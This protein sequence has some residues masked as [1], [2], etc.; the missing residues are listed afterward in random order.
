MNMW[1]QLNQEYFS[2]ASSDSDQFH[3]RW[4]KISISGTGKATWIPLIFNHLNCN[5]SYLIF[6][7]FIKILDSEN[8]WKSEIEEQKAVIEKLKEDA[9][10]DSDSSS[11]P[12][13]YKKI[14]KAK[15]I[16]NLH[17]IE[18]EN[19][20]LKDELKDAE[21]KLQAQE[22]KLDEVKA[23]DE[24]LPDE[25]KGAKKAVLLKKLNDK[26]NEIEKLEKTQSQLEGEVKTLEGKL[27]EAEDNEGVPKEFEGLKKAALIK[28]I[29]D[30]KNEIEDLHQ[31]NE[32]LKENDAVLQKLQDENER[33]I[34]EVEKTEIKIRAESKD[35]CDKLQ[36][37]NERNGLKSVTVQSG[38]C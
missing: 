36:H 31:E 17:Q 28:K 27:K 6:I 23:E 18:A 9:D 32:K 22:K 8:L 21:E 35:L 14:G 16:Q 15:I 10:E 33:L 29:N 30:L 34:L 11:V 7:D 26:N 19:D 24:N 38:R 3:F 2:P 12:E 37:E 20:K 25:Y 1:N 5:A 13:A 4:F